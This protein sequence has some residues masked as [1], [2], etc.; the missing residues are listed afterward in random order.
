MAFTLPD[1]PFSKDALKPHISEEAFEYHHGK[2]HAAYVN[3]LNKLIEGTEFE[4]MT[5]ENIILN[6]EGGIFNNSAQSWNHTFFWNSLSPN[7]GGIPKGALFDEIIKSFASFEDFKT[8]FTDSAITLF[9]SGWV[10]LVKNPDGTLEIVQTQNA[11]TPLTVGKKP[12]ITLDVWEH[13]YYIDYRNA[14]PKFVEAFWE[15]VNWDF[16]LKNFQS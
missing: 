3:N 11:G 8:K 15:I 14:R 16:A 1:L 4:Q 5:L 2:H 9:G 7:G 6:S 12:I 10:W 13:A